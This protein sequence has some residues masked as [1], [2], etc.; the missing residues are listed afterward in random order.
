MVEDP[1]EQIQTPSNG[2]A[3][4]DFSFAAHR[5]FRMILKLFFAIA[6]VSLVSKCKQ[7]QQEPQEPQLNQKMSIRRELE[8][9]TCNNK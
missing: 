8:S 5:R 6:L 7:G 2:L 1:V 4:N 3:Q 9:G